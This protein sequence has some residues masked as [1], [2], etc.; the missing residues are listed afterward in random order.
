MSQR[1]AVLG[2]GVTGESVLRHLL[3]RGF[4]AVVLDTRPAR[5]VD[6]FDAEFRWDVQQWPGLTVD[7][8]VAGQFQ[9][10]LG[11]V[12]VIFG[13]ADLTSNDPFLTLTDLSGYGPA[14]LDVMV[15]G[16]TMIVDGRDLIAIGDVG[17]GATAQAKL[18]GT[19]FAYD[20]D[21][22][23]INWDTDGMGAIEQVSFGL[24]AE[25]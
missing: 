5:Q 22:M 6:A 1:A 16:G 17:I 11:A 19:L 3:A 13:S 12:G 18:N 4:E 9:V 7:F 10:Q 20:T 24:M 14:F 2:F 25:S 21:E 15:T 8:A 23:A